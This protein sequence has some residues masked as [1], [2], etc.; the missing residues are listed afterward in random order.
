[1]SAKPGH[2]DW[3][4]VRERLARARE[5]LDRQWSEDPARVAHVW[6]ERAKALA[7]RAAAASE[8]K[9]G[10][11]ALSFRLGPERYAIAL[12][13]LAGIVP[14]RRYSRI[15]GSR[16]G[17]MG[18]IHVGGAIRPVADL[19][20]MLGM[21]GGD[22]TARAYAVLLGRE[23]SEVGVAV[24]ALEGVLR[25]AGETLEDGEDSAGLPRRLVKRRFAD[26]LS[27]LDGNAIRAHPMFQERDEHDPQDHA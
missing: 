8:E 19:S 25:L 18:V 4:E 5:A 10:E 1:M 22:G 12:R 15:P 23:T 17:L 2:I 27:L 20:R 11:G 3:E 14:L 9:E 7:G 13:E 16:E 21:D 6:R 24:D 26:G